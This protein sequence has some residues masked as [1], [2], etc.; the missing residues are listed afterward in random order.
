MTY[1]PD[2]L[3]SNFNYRNAQTARTCRARN[4]KSRQELL[5]FAVRYSSR[6]AETD[7]L[8]AVYRLDNKKIR[9]FLIF[10][11]WAENRMARDEIYFTET[12]PYQAEHLYRFLKAERRVYSSVERLWIEAICQ[13][14]TGGG[15]YK[16]CPER[17]FS[18]VALT[19]R[20]DSPVWGYE[21]HATMWDPTRTVDNTWLA[22]IVRHPSIAQIN[23]VRRVNGAVWVRDEGGTLTIFLP[24]Q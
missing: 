24:C 1:N 10:M 18:S 22:A 11:D 7:W 23:R 2:E 14:D 21:L 17:T 16:E 9:E 5:E 8:Y 3:I 12:T 13:F 15:K 20:E 4:L 6:Y 19:K